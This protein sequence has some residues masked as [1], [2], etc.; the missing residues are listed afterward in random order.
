MIKAA[1]LD[2]DGTVY[3]H[4]SASVPDSAFAAFSA[5]RKKGVKLFGCTGRHMAELKS[6]NLDTLPFDG[7]V[8][9][10]GARCIAAGK[11]IRQ[12]PISGHDL[13]VLMRE[14]QKDP[15]P[16]IFLSEEDM[17]LNMASEKVLKDLD[18]IHT[19]LPPIRQM[20][21]DA[22]I[23]VQVIPYI[24]DE[25][26]HHIEQQMKEVRSV[27]WGGGALDVFHKDA[28]KDKGME[29]IMDHYGFAK[30]EVLAVG[31]GPND[32]A[33]AR[34]AGHMAAMGNADA[35]LKNISE[36]IG[37]HID[38]DGLWDIFSHYGLI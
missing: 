6:M 27:S 28:G 12:K 16:V 24:D 18:S 22:D 34:A 14:L 26:W 17:F 15:F 11:V 31:D 19:P 7:W 32:L 13:Q 33:C 21:A 8:L 38:E 23:L 5:A 10:N 25:R 3:S 2:I 29:A 1:F 4:F 9:V 35:G 30:D 37:R 20:D 36:Y